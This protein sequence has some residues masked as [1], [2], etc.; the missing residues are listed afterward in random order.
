MEHG[1]RKPVVRAL[2][3]ATAIA[4]ALSPTL[5][6][7]AAHADVREGDAR[8]MAGGGSVGGGPGAIDHVDM[9]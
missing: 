2:A 3:C 9:P 6:S 7:G 4:L 8:M 5:P 1:S